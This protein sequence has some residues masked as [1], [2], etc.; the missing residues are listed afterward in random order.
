M[1]NLMKEERNEKKKRVKR[2][3]IVLL[4][5]RG[6]KQCFVYAMQDIYLL[7]NNFQGQ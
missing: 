3:R 5:V 7:Q 2:E 1:T 4:L 6:L